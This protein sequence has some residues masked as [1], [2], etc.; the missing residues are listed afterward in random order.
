MIKEYGYE[1]DA[2]LNN[3][4]WKKTQGKVVKEKLWDAI[5][6][7]SGRDALKVI[8]REY[9]SSI[10]LVP[11]L[12]CDSMV[13]PFVMYGFEIK[14]YPYSCNYSGIVE[15]IER[16]IQSKGSTKQILLLYMDYFGH[17]SFSDADLYHLKNLYPELIFVEDRTHTLL[18]SQNRFFKADYTIASIRKWLNIPDGGLLWTNRSLKNSFFNEDTSFS[19][20]RL[21]AQCM[22]RDYFNTGNESVKTEYRKIFSSVSNVLDCNMEPTRMSLYAYYLIKMADFDAIKSVRKRNSSALISILQESGIKMLQNNTGSSDLYVPFLIEDRDKKQSKLS[23]IGIFNT[24]IWPISTE[25]ENACQVTRKTVKSMLAAPCD[26][27]YTIDDMKYIGNQ[28]VRVNN[29]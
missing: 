1:Y 10:V 26:Q 7:R 14:Y 2:S 9:E 22:R 24:I 8:A 29:E 21:R 13:L 28:I 20:I 6:L 16:F 18:S 23:A 25:Q 19:D 15:N 5:C 27:R 4:L 17:Q 3:S 11:A 12:S